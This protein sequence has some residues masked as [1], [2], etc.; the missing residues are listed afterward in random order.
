MPKH[1]LSQHFFFSRTG[2]LKIKFP[3]PKP[4]RPA[5]S[6]GSLE[7]PCLQI[8]TLRPLLRYLEEFVVSELRKKAVVFKEVCEVSL[9][10][11]VTDH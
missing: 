11:G 1:V 3:A 2:H 6:N 10:Q 8:L 4:Y 9:C 5:G 7:L